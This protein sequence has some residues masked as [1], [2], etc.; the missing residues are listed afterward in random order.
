MEFLK[1][2]TS[3]SNGFLTSTTKVFLFEISLFH[4]FPEISILL[5]FSL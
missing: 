4:D 5:S 1:V 2:P 3:Y